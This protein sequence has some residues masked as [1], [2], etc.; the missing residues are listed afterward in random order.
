M[1]DRIL[2]SLV[3]LSLALM[4][5]LYLRSRDHEMLDDVPIPVQISSLEIFAGHPVFV[6]P[7]FFKF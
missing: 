3:A 2:S 7:I 4:V 5:W 6:D 1:L